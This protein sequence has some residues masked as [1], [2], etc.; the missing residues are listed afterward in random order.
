MLAENM[1]KLVELCMTCMLRTIEF[2]GHHVSKNEILSMELLSLW[3]KITRKKV[4]L[5]MGV[6]A[7]K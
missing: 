7:R 4:I 5:V 3:N 6:T 1:P 2:L